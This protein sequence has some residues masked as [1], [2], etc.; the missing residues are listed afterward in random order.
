[1]TPYESRRCWRY[2]F[3]LCLL[4]FLLEGIKLRDRILLLATSHDSWIR[5]SSMNWI[6]A[7]R[8]SLLLKGADWFGKIS[9]SWLS[10]YIMMPCDSRRSWRDFDDFP[11]QWYFPSSLSL[12]RPR[13]IVQSSASNSLFCPFVGLSMA[14]FSKILS[15]TLTISWK[16]TLV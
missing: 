12:I 10:R 8:L 1:M 3:R 2:F 6:T 5:A 13:T 4:Q 11:I 7:I 16:G 14:W 9:R 15:H